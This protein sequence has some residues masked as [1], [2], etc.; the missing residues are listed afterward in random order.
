[1]DIVRWVVTI[2]CLLVFAFSM[3]MAMV[4]FAKEDY[5]VKWCMVKGYSWGT[6][7]VIALIVIIKVV[8]I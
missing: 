2:I 3:I 4:N 1:M 5:E 6:L 8:K 7:A